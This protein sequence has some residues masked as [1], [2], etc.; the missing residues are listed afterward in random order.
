[1]WCLV[2]VKFMLNVSWI[3]DIVCALEVFG[4]VVVIVVNMFVG[5]V[6]DVVFWVLMFGNGIGGLFGLVIKFFVL[7]LVC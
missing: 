6:V 4:V 5:F 2:I 1:M 7:W 3:D